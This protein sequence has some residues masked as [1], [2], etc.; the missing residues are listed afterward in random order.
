VGEE[1]KEGRRTE[2]EGT[3]DP[4]L[5]DV[6]SLDWGGVTLDEGKEDDNGDG[7]LRFEPEV[8]DTRESISTGRV[9][10]GVPEQ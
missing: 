7:L 10:T 1:E 6:E 9:I 3:Y 8:V 2:E 4:I 5:F